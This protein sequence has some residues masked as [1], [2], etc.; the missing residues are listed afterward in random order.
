MAEME[1][2]ECFGGATPIPSSGTNIIEGKILYEVA[3]CWCTQPVKAGRNS[4]EIEI[5]FRRLLN[6]WEETWIKSSYSYL[7]VLP[8]P[9]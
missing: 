8:I 2:T 3:R 7:L 9:F 5:A 6:E 1:L 4:L